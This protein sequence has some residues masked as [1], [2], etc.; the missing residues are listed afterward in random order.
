MPA[1]NHHMSQDMIMDVMMQT[2]QIQMIGILTNQKKD[3]ASIPISLCVDIMMDMMLVLAK[4][5]EVLAVMVVVM[6]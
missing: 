1:A 3:Q 2:Y 6:R 5:E 4:V